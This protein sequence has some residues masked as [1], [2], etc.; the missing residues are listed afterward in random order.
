MSESR[1]R[2]AFPSKVQ[3]R[4]V[5]DGRSRTVALEP[6]LWEAFSEI[7]RRECESP[8]AF[9]EI[10]CRHRGSG[11]LARTIRLF[12]IR[13]FREA[14]RLPD[15]APADLGEPRP[16]TSLSACA[17]RALDACGPPPDA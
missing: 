9:L 12:I 17:L 16:R 11:P 6:Q 10:L 5:V 3:R 1:Y 13:Y 2:S 4:V 15:T 14:S 8:P 7:C